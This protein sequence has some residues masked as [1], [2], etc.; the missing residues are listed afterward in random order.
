MPVAPN[1]AL[2]ADLAEMPV[3]DISLR[4]LVRRVGL[5]KTNVVRYFETREAVFFALLN[6]AISELLDDLPS[7]LPHATATQPL[8]LPAPSWTPWPGR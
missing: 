5:S 8:S 4:E 6:Q 7:E 3:S 2:R 1:S